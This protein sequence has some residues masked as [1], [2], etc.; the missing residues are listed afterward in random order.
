MSKINNVYKGFKF[1]LF[2]II[3]IAF[4]GLGVEKTNAVSMNTNTALGPLS[5]NF[6]VTASGGI[7]VRLKN[8]D[9]GRVSSQSGGNDYV[10][11]LPVRGTPQCT[12]AAGPGC[13]TFI[14]TTLG[15]V[16]FKDN[17][18]KNF[19]GNQNNDD[20]RLGFQDA[21]DITGS[22][23]KALTEL[24][25]SLATE[26]GKL[27]LF[28]R[29]NAYYDFALYG[30]IGIGRDSYDRGI[31]DDAGR[32]ELGRKV[33][34]LDLS[35]SWDYD[36]PAG[37]FVATVPVSLKIGKLAAN[38]WGEATFSFT[39]IS[40]GVVL[41]VPAARRPGA[42]IKE[43][44]G[45]EYMVYGSVGLPFDIG[46]DAYYQFQH[47]PWN[48]SPSDSPFAISDTPNPSNPAA[49][50]L[51]LSGSSTSGTF[52]RNCAGTGGLISSSTGANIAPGCSTDSITHY[53][54]RYYDF[55]GRA[56]DL[57]LANGDLFFARV[58][59][60]DADDQG[61]WGVQLSYYLPLLNGI[62]FNFSYQNVHSR[63]PYARI[64]TDGLPVA[65]LSVISPSS[66]ASSNSLNGL[67]CTGV[68]PAFAA[69]SAAFGG[70]I[71]TGSF[72]D[73]TLQPGVSGDTT[74]D[75]YRA[76]G[77]VIG[78]LNAQLAA[79]QAG[80]RE[81][82]DAD[83]LKVGI[84]TRH[85]GGS[86]PRDGVGFNNRV[87]YHSSDP[88]QYNDLTSNDNSALIRLARA[89][90]AALA[91]TA[92]G[93]TATPLV[94][95]NIET[96]IKAQGLNRYDVA[97][98]NCAIYKNAAV[99]TGLRGALAGINPQLA[100]LSPIGTEYLSLQYNVRMDLYFPENLK[101]VGG[102]FNTTIPWLEWGLQGEVA[103][104][105]DTPLQQD[106]TEQIIAHASGQ[107]TGLSLGD[108]A[109]IALG[110]LVT[111]GG[112]GTNGLS[113]ADTN[114]SYS[115]SNVFVPGAATSPGTGT[116]VA[117]F[118]P[119]TIECF[120]DGSCGGNGVIEAD[121]LNITVGTT[122]LY[123]GSHPIIRLLGADLG[124]FLMEFNAIAFL[125][126]IPEGWPG[127]GNIARSNKSSTLACVRVSGTELPLGGLVG[128][129]TVDDFSCTPDKTSMG[130]TILG[131]LDYNNVF[132]TAWRI[133]P[134]LSIRHGVVGNTPSPIPGWRKDTI[135]V[136]AGLGF[137]F[138]NTWGINI[139]Y[140]GYFDVGHQLYNSNSG[141]DTFSFNVSYAF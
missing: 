83:N 96:N 50:N 57:R 135:S 56:E 134:S 63:L 22:T 8:I 108:A 20:G 138:Q 74:T 10:R 87:I 37:V 91:S 27:T 35:L 92:G 102:S 40:Q 3:A 13:L 2:G 129:D 116:F 130:Y 111:T 7:S 84:D 25:V 9:P 103:W 86:A 19:A 64:K 136:N 58:S 38:N 53:T 61:Q 98:I 24:E 59:H 133:R 52:R 14:P 60:I 42:Q 6:D 76:P 15:S 16:G 43:I 30:G 114:W 67:G 94:G 73:P 78:A 75:G 140:V 54:N 132:G 95:P 77:G 62:E 101:I 18:D 124:I 21:G 81:L 44:I 106:V 32:S 105:P 41:D 131:F 39:G 45:T 99:N 90:D 82:Q 72:I 128:L 80:A 89:A 121:M 113:I 139:G 85:F 47:T 112:D 5:V 46:L 29:L 31:P 115:I 137:A 110:P 68:N 107:G 36:V 69:A 12:S 104:R 66:A 122:A 70:F 28:N 1:A 117:G 49:Y 125:N 141:L 88:D 97:R 123:N 119:N 23:V 127:S 109:G 65:T 33:K 26:Y 93:A 17:D 79:A 34:L 126:D 51:G 120:L 11:F 100:A 118:N 4:F 55:N 48:L 71:A